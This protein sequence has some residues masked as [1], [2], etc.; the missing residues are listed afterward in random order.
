MSQPSPTDRDAVASP[1]TGECELDGDARACTGCWRT[2]DEIVRWPHMTHEE[3]RA[4]V[5][6]LALD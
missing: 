5:D 1:C 4:V 2:L 3:R 6:R